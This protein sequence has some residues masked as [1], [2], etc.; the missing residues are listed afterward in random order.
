EFI[1]DLKRTGRAQFNENGIQGLG[2]IFN[3]E[4]EDYAIIVTAEDIFGKSKLRNLLQILTVGFIASLLIVYFIGI[5]S[6]EKAFQPVADKIKQVKTISANNLHQRLHVLDESDEIGELATT[7]NDL[8]ERLELSFE[9][10]KK[11]ISNASHEI[12]NPLAAIMGEAEVC[13]SKE[14][15]SEAYRHSLTVIQNQAGRLNSLVNNLLHLAKTGFDEKLIRKDSVKMDDLLFEIIENLQFSAPESKVSV[16]IN[17][18][19]EGAEIFEIRGNSNLLKSAISNLIENG[20]KFSQNKPVSVNLSANDKI[21]IVEVV[22]QGIGIP[23][24]EIK[25]IFEPFYRAENARVFSGFGI[26]LPLTQRIL[27]LH[28]GRLQFRT[29]EGEGSVFSIEFTK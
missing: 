17:N 10:Q 19:D 9:M 25:N 5:F 29:K 14:R 27:Q 6:A 16:Q 26:G 11:F 15:S 1:Q 12:R 24:N 20:C 22:D 2:K 3:V 28:G 13:L 8:L 18:E 23:E 4:N 21:V 7:F